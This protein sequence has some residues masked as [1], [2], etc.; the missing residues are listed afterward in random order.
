M[1][2]AGSE[3]QA[4]AG[5]RLVAP[6][7]PSEKLDVTVVLRPPARA[8]SGAQAEAVSRA[9][10][11]RI[12]G[13]QP[14]DVDAVRAF[15]HAF[16]LRLIRISLAERTIVLSGSVAACSRAF[17]VSLGRYEAGDTTY[18]GREG[19]IHLPEGLTGVV[20]A[21]LGLDD[22]PAAERR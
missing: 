2:L 21:V 5:A 20:V 13:A 3:R 22:R 6:A 12:D 16:G 18:R 4:P 15:A 8:Q 17:Q 7:D 11:A 14:A 9:D 19:A 10:F 1:A